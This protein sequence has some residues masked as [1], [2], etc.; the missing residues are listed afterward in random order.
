MKNKAKDLRL[1]TI[2]AEEKFE[3]DVRR[4]IRNGADINTR[5]KW[6]ETF[7]H[8]AIWRDRPALIEFLIE[9][10]ADVNAKDGQGWTPLHC[11]IANKGGTKGGAY[12]LTKY[13]LDHGADVKA[14]IQDKDNP[15]HLAAWFD[16]TR[17]VRLLIERG[18]DVY[19]DQGEQGT[20]LQTAQY[21]GKRKVARFLEDYIHES[22]TAGP[23]KVASWRRKVQGQGIELQ[24]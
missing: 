24:R 14:K 10:G 23:K 15:L 13:L 12:D 11:V 1:A 5:N 3:R 7:L 6:G 2:R 17:L 8:K 21:F 22:K 19:D 16:D 20:P 9:R 18:A 4:K